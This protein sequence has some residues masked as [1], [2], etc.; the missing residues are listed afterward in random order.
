MATKKT[1]SRTAKKSA[2]KKSLKKTAAAESS[3]GKASVEKG[4]KF[5][6]EVADLYRL[7]GAQVV[8]NIEIHQKKVDILATFRIP[9]S[10]HEHSVII[11]CKDEQRSVAA[12]QRI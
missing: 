4:R 2:A 1:V 5:E 11:E 12:N 10:T 8:Q 6:D 7:L 9:G 3:K